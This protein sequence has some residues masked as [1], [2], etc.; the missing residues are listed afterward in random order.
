MGFYRD[1][2]F[3]ESVTRNL[4]CAGVHNARVQTVTMY[5]VICDDLPKQDPIIEVN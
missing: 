1:K 2:Q 5:E 3:A 4:R